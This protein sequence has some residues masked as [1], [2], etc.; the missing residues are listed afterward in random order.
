MTRSEPETSADKP[1]EWNLERF[2]RGRQE[3]LKPQ[4]SSSTEL[5]KWLKSRKNLITAYRFGYG[6]EPDQRRYFELLKQ[7][8]ELQERRAHGPES[9]S[10]NTDA[11]WELAYAYREGAGVGR[12]NEDYFDWLHRAAEAGDRTAMADLAEEYRETNRQDFLKWTRKLA[13]DPPA[14]KALIDLAESYRDGGGEEENLEEYFRHAERAVHYAKEAI[15]ESETDPDVENRASEDLPQALRLLAEAYK[16]GLG[17]QE[18][19][20]DY[21]RNL[22][23]AIKAADDAV[24]FAKKKREPIQAEVIAKETAAPIREELA[25]KLRENLTDDSA[26]RRAFEFM[27]RA[28]KEQRPSAMRNLALMYRDGIGTKKSAKQYFYWIK[29]AAEAGDPDGMYQCALAYGLGKGTKP[30]ATEFLKWAE[31]SIKKGHQ[32][33]SMMINLADLQ[34]RQLIKPRSVS[35]TL[36]IFDRL[37][38]VV[39]E[40]KSRHILKPEQTQNGIAH[41]TTLAA[42]HSMLPRITEHDPT[43]KFEKANLLRLY[44]ISYV[45]DPQEGQ[46]LISHESK[47]NFL[48]GFFQA[49]D[50]SSRR[51]PITAVYDPRPLSGL[52]YSVF[53]GSFTLLADRLDLWRAYGRD[54]EGYCIVT[55]TNLFINT[56]DESDPGFAGLVGVDRPTREIQMTL[57]H[58][59]YSEEKI[60]KTLDALKSILDSIRKLPSIITRNKL[61]YM[62]VK[63]KIDLTAREILSDILFLYKNEEYSSEHEVRMLAPSAVTAHSVC[64]DEQTPG[65]LYVKTPNFLFQARAKIIIGPKVKHPEAVRLE[66]QHRLDRNGHTNVEVEF[67]QIRYR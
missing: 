18:S 60:E 9:E 23:A 19:M 55:P 67:S 41:F 52:T 6:T 4:P 54:G 27:E 29:R 49:Q 24:E 51:L 14:P 20:G 40:I 31:N 33:A 44:E 46:T 30:D 8:A 37:R 2:E 12:S 42:L 25:L 5:K 57:Y 3:A 13:Q 64:V 58:V 21:M 10:L 43:T 56:H 38:T 35:H 11:M 66:L 63:E 62:Q 61:A 39:Q 1:E 28:A 7:V 32:K 15:A 26:C 50:E 45:N 22:E 59:F 36:E 17:T 47:N 34:K 53:V 65:R 48:R 16:D